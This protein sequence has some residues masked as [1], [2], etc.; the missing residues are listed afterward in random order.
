[1]WRKVTSRGLQLFTAGAL[2]SKGFSA[3]IG[4]AYS[5]SVGSTAT[6][7]IWA[8]VGVNLL[9]A[10]GLLIGTRTTVRVVQGYLLFYVIIGIIVV[11]TGGP[12]DP[13]YPHIF[14]MT[15]YVIGVCEDVILLILLLWSTS[16]ALT[17]ATYSPNQSL[18]PTAG[19]RDAH[20]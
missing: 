2:A 5:L 16:K 15:A 9:M 12:K 17:S 19:R 8:L 10:L 4:F 1:M 18:E 14:S 3:W 6:A 7:L 13:R 20:I 11:T